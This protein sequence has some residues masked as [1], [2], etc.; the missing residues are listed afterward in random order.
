MQS[1]HVRNAIAIPD[2]DQGLDSKCRVIT[3]KDE[4]Q[5]SDQPLSVP[6]ERRPPARGEGIDKEEGAEVK[7]EVVEEEEA[8]PT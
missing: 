1:I 7:P 6:L 5:G 4:L 8:I 2:P 3:P